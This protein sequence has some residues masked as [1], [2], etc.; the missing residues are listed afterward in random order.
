MRSTP[1]LAI[2]VFAQLS[3]PAAAAEPVIGL[4]APLSGQ[5]SSLGEQLHDGARV[6]AFGRSAGLQV[7]DTACSAEGGAAAARSLVAAGVDMVVGFLCTQAIEAALPILSQAKVAVITPGIRTDS[8]TD[9]R[10][11]TGWLV[12]RLAPRAS[13]E[14]AALASVLTRRWRTHHFAIIDDGTIYG[15]E[16]AESFRLAAEQVGLE[17][18]YVDTFR[19]QLDNQ[20]ALVGRLERSGATHVLAGG[21]RDDLAILGRDSAELGAGLTIAGGEAL[22]ASA[23]PVD[24]Q[25]GTLMV[26]L[27]EWADLAHQEA[28]AALQR[29]NVRAQGYVLPAY[30][31]VEIAIAALH[32]ARVDGRQPGEILADGQFETALGTVSFDAKGDWDHNAYRLFQ[33]RDGRFVVLD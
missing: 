5:F 14:T 22:R 33:Y 26:G 7:A 21:D 23:G 32:H 11:R 17:P 30:A 19:P 1:F 10:D 16:L 27:P 24:L 9:R 15:R 6:G 18:A 13:D 8:L 20:I 29:E 25:P 2:A 28:L 3:W 12:F 31:A 4:A